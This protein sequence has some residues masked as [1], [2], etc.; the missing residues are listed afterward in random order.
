[1]CYVTD[2][3][4]VY[5]SPQSGNL[6][7]IWSG[8]SADGSALG[9]VSSNTKPMTGP[10]IQDQEPVFSRDGGHFGGVLK[11]VFLQPNNPEDAE[12]MQL[13]EIV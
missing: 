12:R 8:M 9:M 7:I 3:V 1:M 10:W 5:K 6:Y 2:R 13:L 11:L 4:F